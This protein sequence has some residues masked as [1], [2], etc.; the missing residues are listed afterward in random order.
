MNTLDQHHDW[1]TLLA[2]DKQAVDSWPNVE[3]TYELI[4][5]WIYSM[6]FQLSGNWSVNGVSNEY[7]SRVILAY[8]LKVSIK[9]PPW[10]PVVN[11]ISKEGTM[12]YIVLN[13]N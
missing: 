12:K 10:M 1:Y 6:E 3:R 11:M 7:W 9:T 2:V 8:Q 5:T 13:S 4:E